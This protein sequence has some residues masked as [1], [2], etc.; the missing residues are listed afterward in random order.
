MKIEQDGVEVEVY[1]AAERDAAV[2]AARA[3][4]EGEWKPKLTAAEAEKVRLDGLLKTRAEEF[5]GFRKLS[6]EQVAA[7]DV[8]Q[9]TIYE[10]GLALNEEREKSAGLEKERKTNAI[11]ATIRARVGADDKLFEKVKTAYEI[12]NLTDDTPERI[13]ARVN[14]ALGVLGT[15]EPDIMAQIAGFGGGGYTPP[16]QKKEDKSF[17]DTERGKAGAAELGLGLEEAKK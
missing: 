8:A 12:V 11:A 7:L 17:A 10:N 15:Q 9:R 2:T 3:E 5:K 13:E 1:T 14:A 6:D 16:V 4:V